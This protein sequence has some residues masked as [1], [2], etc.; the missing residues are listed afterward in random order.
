MFDAET[1]QPCAEYAYAFETAA[2]ANERLGLP[3]AEALKRGEIQGC[4]LVAVDAHRF[5]VL[6]RDGRGWDG[7]ET[8]LPAAVKTVWLVDIEGATDLLAHPLPSPLEAGPELVLPR[9]QRLLDLVASRWKALAPGWPGLAAKWEGLGLRPRAGGGYALLVSSDNDFLTPTLR[10]EGRDVAFPK[11]RRG[12]DTQF[13]LFN[14][15]L[16][17]G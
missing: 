10:L 6:E 17:P 8:W 16:P 12:V 7:A 3:G 2:Q 5:L 13:L 9:K 15:S 14:L 4:E 1:G 11:A